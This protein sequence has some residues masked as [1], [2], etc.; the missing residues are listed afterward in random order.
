[1]GV[2]RELAHVEKTLSDL[3]PSGSTGHVPDSD[4]PT[5][6]RIDESE[7]REPEAD[8][9]AAADHQPAPGS[10]RLPAPVAFGLVA[11]LVAVA[12]AVLI[13][14]QQLNRHRTAPT[15]GP[16]P[17]V[18]VSP[19]PTVMAALSPE[20]PIDGSDPAAT[21]TPSARARLS[22]LIGEARL[23]QREGDIDR[24]IS[25]LSQAALIE[26]KA[27]T[28]I[29]TARALV[30]DL[31]ARADTAADDA[32][33]DEASELV[34]RAREL[35][36]RFELPTD[37]M[38]EA[39]RRHARLERFERVDPEDTGRLAELTGLRALVITRNERRFEGFIHNVRSGML[40]LQQA[41]EV[42]RGGSLFHV[43]EI[44]LD[45]VVEIRV[46]PD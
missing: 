10:R 15:A 23:A 7:A 22:S 19:S 38:D 13:V 12:A 2:A 34:G 5:S 27:H 40:E 25:L 45:L 1:M 43:E 14:R 32:R 4:E 31:L 46:Y 44:D 9:D 18:A 20:P 6:A 11:V 36:I 33:W 29:S 17:A 26:S 24:A 35:A 30:S 8:V 16:T 37:P 28:V 39:T 3:D 21:P 42:G 41:L